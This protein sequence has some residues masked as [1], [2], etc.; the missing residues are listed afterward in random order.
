M[1][2]AVIKCSTNISDLYQ[3]LKP[4]EHQDKR[5]ALRIKKNKNNLEINITA[6]DAT[7]L[8]AMV[9][10]ITRLLTIYE[11]KNE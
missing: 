9:A 11:G 6:Q 1:Y 7:S 10:S 3:A 8:R 5:A 4:E 2:Q